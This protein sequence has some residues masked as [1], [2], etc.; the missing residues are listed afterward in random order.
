MPNT[1]VNRV[2]RRLLGFTNQDVI[3]RF[4]K[5]TDSSITSIINWDKIEA[6]NE[7]LSD[8][9]NRINGIIF[10]DYSLSSEE[11][12]AFKEKLDSAYHMLRD[13]RIVE[14]KFNNNGRAGE[15]VYYN[16]MR[17]YL[18]SVY[19]LKTIAAMFQ[20]EESDIEQLGRD[21]LQLLSET[22]NIEDFKKDAIADLTIES[23]HMHIEIQAGFTGDNDIKRSKAENARQRK[24][25]N[26]WQTVVLHFDIFNGRVAAV[27]ISDLLSTLPRNRWESNTRFEGVF[28]TPIPEEC[29]KWR[30]TNP[31]P[32]EESFI[33]TIR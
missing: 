33:T 32:A 3:K 24:E 30:I 20:V 6:H 25:E 10:P 14:L 31:L 29:F 26:N 17:G 15:G 21:N 5:A 18:V 1:D 19:F 12:T 27:D 28:T 8:I 13:F 9:F 4:F 2:Y 7:R 22:G 16:W 11:L 23:K